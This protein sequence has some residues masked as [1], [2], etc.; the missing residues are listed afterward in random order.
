MA[1]SSLRQSISRAA[2][3]EA[4]RQD[5]EQRNQRLL[6]PHTE[7]TTP[8]VKTLPPRLV[9]A[10]GGTLDALST[11]KFLKQDTG[12][13]DNAVVG[14]LNNSP[15]RVAGLGLALV[16]ATQLLWR[17]LGKKAPAL[18]NAVAAN[19]GALQ[20][21]YGALNMALSGSR[22]AGTSAADEYR[23]ALVRGLNQ[24]VR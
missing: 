6:T 14:G 13:E 24:G 15:A 17:A 4:L 11:Y 3:L 1:Q 8:A 16:P 12:R 23:A 21:G 7:P 22:F 18:A 5:Q 10:L 20:A 2:L 9:S 19:Q